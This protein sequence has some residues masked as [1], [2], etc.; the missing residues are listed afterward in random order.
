M[1][2]IIN[3]FETIPS[4]HRSLILVGGL[5]FFWLL[6][7]TLPLV[8]FKYKKWKHAIPNIFFT[9]TTIIINF[10]LAF[11]LLESADWV[12]KNQFG[13]INWIPQLPLWAYALL[14]VLLLDFIGAYLAH[15]VEHKV[16]P[17]WMVHLVHHTDHNVDTTT[18]NRHHP[19]ESII[20]FLFTLAGV[21]IVG[22]P[23]AIVFLYQSL[24]LVA[25]QFSHANIKLPT[26][27]DKVLSYII[28]S[29]NMHKVHHHYKLPY[30]DSNYGNIFSIWDRLFG[31]FMTLDPKLIV[32]GVDTFPDE[33]SNGK[34]GVLLK[35]PFHK[36]RKPTTI[37]SQ[38]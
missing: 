32:Y 16:K 1:E 24:S 2:T 15:Y 5:T 35:Q 25:T 33:N 8:N 4:I 34:I 38:K 7:G 23:I 29:P 6:E 28:V 12:E 22:A 14:G 30:T 27:V 19:L 21:Y 10:G 18:A 37:E 13:I 31:T 9:L 36:Y 20:R 17:L 11:L 3:Y 26:K